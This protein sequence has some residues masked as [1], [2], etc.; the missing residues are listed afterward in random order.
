[1]KSEVMKLMCFFWNL[2]HIRI[3]LHVT[4]NIYIDLSR[5]F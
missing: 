2:D 1:M 5:I 4:T 3:H